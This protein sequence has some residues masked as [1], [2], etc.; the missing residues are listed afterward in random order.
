M[1]VEVD[2]VGGKAFQAI[3]DSGHKVIMDA[4]PAVGGENRGSRPMEMIL[5]G[6]G[7]CS[8]IDVVMML[9]KSRQDVTDCRV[10]IEAQRAE[11]I[12]A[13]FT[14]INMHFIVTGR[15]LNAKQVERAVKL[16]AEKYCS[17]SIMLSNTVEMSHDVE[18]RETE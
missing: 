15:G 6:L 18:I 9:E 13:V 10:V 3:A 7:G 16:S 17:V 11:S 4:S 8:S 5:M 2:W 1:K 12:P 14:H